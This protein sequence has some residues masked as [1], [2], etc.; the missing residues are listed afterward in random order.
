F[1]FV[2]YAAG[3][4]W[5]MSTSMPLTAALALIITLVDV[6]DRD[7]RPLHL[8]TWVSIVGAMF[9]SGAG[10]AF[11]G[12]RN[13]RWAEQNQFLSTI[14]AT[15]QVEHGLAESL[16]LFLEEL[17]TWFRTE[18][19]FLVFRDLDL[20]R[21]F[22]WRLKSGESERLAPESFALARA[23]GFLLDDFD[24]TLCW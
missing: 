14:T 9:A 18:Q 20:E 1:L 10:L 15:M 11:L 4:R 7:T 21:I 2:S 23:D 13:R 5:G 3:C 17:A 6:V 24:A 16:R 22:L 8:P 19:A 12:D